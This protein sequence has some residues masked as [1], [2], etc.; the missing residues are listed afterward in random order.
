MEIFYSISRSV[1][2]NVLFTSLRPLIVYYKRSIFLF[3]KGI[4][5]LFSVTNNI[6]AE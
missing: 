2:K 1:N 5:T 6:V 4:F 3:T